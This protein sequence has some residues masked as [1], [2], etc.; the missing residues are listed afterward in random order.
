MANGE[1]G[2]ASTLVFITGATSGLGRGIAGTVPWAQHTVIN[3][4]RTSSPDYES[5]FLDL[6]D[7]SSWTTA[8]HAVHEKIACFDGCRVVFVHNAYHPE[9]VGFIGEVDPAALQ[10]H[11]LA[12]VAAPL[13][14]GDAFIRSALARPDLESGL[15]LISS[16]GA[17]I[18]FEGNAVYCA[19]K[20]AVEQWVRVVRAER[21]RRKTGPWIVAIRPG[22]VDTPQLRAAAAEDPRNLPHAPLI[23]RAIE[24]KAYESPQEVGAKIWASVPPPPDG[25]HVVFLGEVPAGVAELSE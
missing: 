1:T 12:N 8:T 23:G 14:L 3:L 7:E 24:E 15:I 25:R 13:V 5:V 22:T 6:T 9:P 17:R 21:R 18:A 4:S 2:A 20:A 19:G 16:A 10:A 11:T